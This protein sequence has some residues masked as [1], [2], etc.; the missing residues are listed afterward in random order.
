MEV[1]SIVLGSGSHIDEFATGYVVEGRHLIN[2]L[3]RPHSVQ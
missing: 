3:P 1:L 2:S